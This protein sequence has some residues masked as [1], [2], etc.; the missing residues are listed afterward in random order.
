MPNFY[1]IEYQEYQYMYDKKIVF[2]YDIHFDVNTFKYFIISFFLTFQSPD[3]HIFGKNS[4][5]FNI[6]QK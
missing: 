5:I 3:K 4:N 6:D 1:V 2:H